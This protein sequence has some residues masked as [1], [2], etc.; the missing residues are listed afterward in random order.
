MRGCSI[1]LGLLFSTA[2][3]LSAQSP[4][5]RLL[6][7]A[8]NGAEFHLIPLSSDTTLKRISARGRMDL[9]V[10]LGEA[11]HFAIVAGDSLSPV[12]VEAFRDARLV[13]SADGRYVAVSRDSSGVSIEARGE[14]PG[15]LRPAARRP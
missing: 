13:A 8:P 3:T 2:F 4:S 14:I 9:A 1:A 5:V 6:V 10:P 11:G 15:S 7:S 12:H